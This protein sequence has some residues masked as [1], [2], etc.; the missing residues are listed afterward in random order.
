MAVTLTID[1]PLATVLR[2][3]AA[4]RDMSLD[5]VG[6]QVVSAGLA[7]FGTAQLP[8]DII[9]LGPVNVSPPTIEQVLRMPWPVI[10]CGPI[11]DRT[12]EP[13]TTLL[14]VDA[15]NAH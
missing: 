6:H 1:E 3:L 15:D 13:I 7:A 12:L 8:P 4:S 11:P 14:G 5:E 10:A 9:D 2:T